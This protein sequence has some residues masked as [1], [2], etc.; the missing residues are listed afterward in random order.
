MALESRLA[1]AHWNLA[2][3]LEVIGRRSAD[4]GALRRALR[5]LA[6]DRDLARVG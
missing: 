2:R 6:C 3:L 1:D 5:H 4:E